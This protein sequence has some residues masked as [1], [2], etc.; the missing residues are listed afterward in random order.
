MNMAD[1][2]PLV[3]IGMPTYNRDRWLPRSIES[4]SNQT[5]ENIELIICDN[6]STDHTYETCQ[7]YLKK[8]P[9]IRYYRNDTNIGMIA[10][11]NRA[12]S[13][14]QGKYLVLTGDDDTYEPGFIEECMIILE[15]N[16][17]VV[18]ATPLSDFP[19][20]AD[21]IIALKNVVDFFNTQG[22]RAYARA[23][24]VLRD[25]TEGRAHLICGLIRREALSRTTMV[26]ADVIKP[27]RILLMELALLGEFRVIN[28]VLRHSGDVAERRKG[29]DDKRSEWYDP[30]K[31]RKLRTREAKDLSEICLL[32]RKSNLNDWEKFRLLLHGLI[33]YSM[34]YLTFMQNMAPLTYNRCRL[35]YLLGLLERL[36]Q[37]F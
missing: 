21:G 13:L 11:T 6:A 20:K 17:E 19:D 28:T 7:E 33:F 2:K 31:G 34:T 14:S 15:E 22:K 4:L 1:N 37:N 23:V 18:L 5:Y 24:K 25:T 3:S 12:F 30:A 36:P 9:R 26:R 35:H 27:D 8:D 32:I 29:P 10:N 16:P